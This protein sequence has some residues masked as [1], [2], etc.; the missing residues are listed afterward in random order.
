MEPNHTA[1]SLVKDSVDLASLPEICIEIQRLA[2]DP[3]TEFEQFGDLVCQDTAL[4]SHL[5]RVV[6]SPYYGFPAQ[7]D[8]VT[9]AIQLIGINELRN[10]TLATS[11]VEIFAK[12]PADLFDML[13]FWRHSVFCALMAKNLAVKCRVLHPERLFIA[14]LLHD[15]GQLVLVTKLPET[16]QQIL[17]TSATSQHQLSDIEI[18]TLGFTH[19]DVG[20]ELLKQWNIPQI[21]TQAVATHHTLAEHCSYE[22]A[23]LHI[24]NATTHQIEQLVLSEAQT[25][26]DPFTAFIE[27][28]LPVEFTSAQTISGVNPWAWQKSGLRIAQLPEVVQ[29]SASGFEA[30]LDILYPL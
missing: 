22:A 6:N 11:A 3:E 9:R 18:A 21:L 7:I 19:A 17:H 26:Y 29:N 25:H 2:D 28:D 1:A 5:L 30:L 23:I 14:G 8:T 15:I 4:A 12:I 16:M 24:A 13:G 27:I 20:G 10:L